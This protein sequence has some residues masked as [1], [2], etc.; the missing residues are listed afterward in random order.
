MPAPEP[1]PRRTAAGIEIDGE[2]RTPSRPDVDPDRARV[3]A[4]PAV[5]RPRLRP[6]PL[7]HR[8]RHRDA[9]LPAGRLGPGRVVRPAPPRRAPLGRRGC[10]GGST[11]RRVGWEPP[12]DAVWAAPPVA[13]RRRA[14]DVPRRSRD[15]GTSC[16]T[17]T[18]GRAHRLGLPASGARGST[19]SPTHCGGSRRPGA[20]S[21][22]SS[23]TTSPAVPDRA[24]RIRGVPRRRTATC[25]A[26]DR[27]AEAIAAPD[28][29]DDRERDGAGRGRRRAAA[30]LGAEGHLE[31]RGGGGAVGPRPPRPA[32]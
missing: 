31:E 7:G 24:A 2:R 3:P 18:G 27:H 10:C 16:G 13:E 21:W 15:R 1:D 14:G 28:G 30:H 4:A 25:P 26:F 12:A 8:R 9:G 32:A 6:E 19:T 11:T 29:G 22:R 23:G 5:R 20:T 17:A